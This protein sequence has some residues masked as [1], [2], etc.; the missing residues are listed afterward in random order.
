[1]ANVAPTMIDPELSAL[2]IELAQLAGAVEAQIGDA[3]AALERRDVAAGERVVAQDRKIDAAQRAVDARAMRLLAKGGL[4]Q[5][6]L[7]EVVMAIRMASEFE[8]VGDLAKNVAKRSVL[9]SSSASPAAPI[10]GL[11]RMGKASLRQFADVL[12]AYGDE[13][14][15]AATAVWTGDDDLDELYDSVFEEIIAAMASD[16]AQI[17]EGAHLVLI[18]KN[19]ERIGDHATNIAE[20]AHYLFTGEQLPEERPKGGASG[21]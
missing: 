6:D 16:R 14:M 1:M 17:R 10:T 15:P 21:R 12:T 13:N 20:A 3:I 4:S 2:E 19:F 5:K 7:R 8:R 18:A 9:V 11:V